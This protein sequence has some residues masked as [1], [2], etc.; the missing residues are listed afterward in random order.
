MNDRL[1]KGR[2]NRQFN[3][4]LLKDVTISLPF[5]RN[6]EFPLVRSRD[7]NFDLQI[8][9]GQT[10]GDTVGPFDEDEAVAVEI[11]FRAEGEKF[12]EV[13]EAIGVEVVDHPP[14]G[15]FLDQDER[16]AHDRAAIDAQR[17]G[18]RLDQAGF[19][20]SQGAAQGHRAAAGQDFG[21]RGPE[22]RGGG[23]VGG[24]VDQAIHDENSLAPAPQ[25]D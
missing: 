19:A 18:D 14:A 13:L 9:A 6:L 4:Q 12:I 5:R 15:V 20:R 8:L 22:R 17:F 11:L 25:R 3:L 1:K 21:Q 7:E 2:S 10:V 24:R 23:F 16:G